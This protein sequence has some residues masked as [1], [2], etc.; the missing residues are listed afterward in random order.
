MILH[1]NHVLNSILIGLR[2]YL[3][4]FY[5]ISITEVHVI[6][7]SWNTYF[8]WSYFSSTF[9]IHTRK[10]PFSDSGQKHN[11]NVLQLLPLQTLANDHFLCVRF[12]ED[13]H[14][15]VQSSSST[16]KWISCAVLCCNSSLVRNVFW[17]L[18][19]SAHLSLS[20]SY[21]SYPT[22]SFHSSVIMITF[23]SVECGDQTDKGQAI[24]D[25]LSC[26]PFMAVTAQNSYCWV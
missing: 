20:F 1:I 24:L 12:V 26:S 5:V 22:R 18:T 13:P 19:G 17:Y 25:I 11:S 6:H 9:E 7:G 23:S 14:G 10:Q 16:T 21:R 4:Q 3:V 2:A 8:D 15:T